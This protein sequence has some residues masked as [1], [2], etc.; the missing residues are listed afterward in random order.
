MLMMPDSGEYRNLKA[1]WF[2]LGLA[3]SLFRGGWVVVFWFVPLFCRACWVYTAW[4]LA[5][6]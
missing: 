6:L 3:V 2:M 5:I 1:C 4:S